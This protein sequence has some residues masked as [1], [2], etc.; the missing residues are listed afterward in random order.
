MNMYMYILYVYILI[1]YMYVHVCRSACLQVTITWVIPSTEFVMK[2]VKSLVSNICIYLYKISSDIASYPF[3][4]SC[5]YHS[6]RNCGRRCGESSGK[7]FV[8]QPQHRQHLSRRPWGECEW[9]GQRWRGAHS[10]VCQFIQEWLGNDWRR[11][12]H[13]RGF[14]VVE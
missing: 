2:T 11:S 12:G 6:N 3:F 1:I 8:L 4:N 7:E 13:Q 5:H 9:R 10:R 14:T